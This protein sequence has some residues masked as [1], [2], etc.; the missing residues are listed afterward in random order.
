[1]I[2]AT[3]DQG[4]GAFR[5]SKRPNHSKMVLGDTDYPED[6]SNRHLAWMLQAMEMVCTHVYVG[7]GIQVLICRLRRL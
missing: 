6:A 3:V 5:I 7:K 4:L 1:V 2:V